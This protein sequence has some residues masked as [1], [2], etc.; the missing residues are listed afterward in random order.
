MWKHLDEA[1]KQEVEHQR[2]RDEDS[3]E[4]FRKLIADTI[5]MG[6]GDAETALRW[7]WGQAD[8]MDD[9][10]FRWGNNLPWKWNFKKELGYAESKTYERH[11]PF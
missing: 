6:A 11:R 2:E 8:Y 5:D 7:L 9:D 4:S 1:Y 10:D 3:K